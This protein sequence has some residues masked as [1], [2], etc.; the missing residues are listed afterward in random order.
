VASEAWYLLGPCALEAKTTITLPIGHGRDHSTSRVSRSGAG[1]NRSATTF[2]H[3]FRKAEGTH[4]I[5][6]RLALPVHITDILL[7]AGA[8]VT[9]L[10][11]NAVT[12][13]D[14]A[15]TISDSSINEATRLGAERVS[16]VR[17]N[18]EGRL[19]IQ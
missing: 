9:E 3:A 2:F 17:A 1:V 6:I 15:L 10:E 5:A 16:L 7:A 4:H 14:I 13:L 8:R 18:H 11:T 19:W 12:V